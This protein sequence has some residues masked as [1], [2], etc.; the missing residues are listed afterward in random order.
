MPYGL[1]PIFRV[2]MLQEN[3]LNLRM[4]FQDD[5]QFRAAVASEAYDSNRDC[6]D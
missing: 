2:A 4:L 6:H 3:G 5:G 1:R